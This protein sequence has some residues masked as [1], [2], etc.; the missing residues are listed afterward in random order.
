MKSK[1]INR[2]R[3]DDC[4]GNLQHLKACFDMIEIL[5]LMGSG[6]CNMCNS[7]QPAKRISAYRNHD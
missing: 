5:K 2:I 4:N 1:P 7:F 3:S 6:I